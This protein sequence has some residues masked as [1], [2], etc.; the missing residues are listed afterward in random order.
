MGHPHPPPWR[1]K[2]SVGP[3]CRS[4]LGC[5]RGGG[6]RLRRQPPAPAPSLLVGRTGPAPPESPCPSWVPAA[7]HPWVLLVG[8]QWAGSDPRVLSLCV[9]RRP[10]SRSPRW[11]RYGWLLVGWVGRLW[12]GLQQKKKKEEE[13]KLSSCSSSFSVN[14]Q[15]FWGKRGAA[16]AW[17][18][19]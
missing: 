18:R 12:K 13:N 5:C 3:P 1:T 6:G 11:E 8:G 4:T 10:A 19:Y 9:L 15:A 14:F 16:W 17:R 7:E 2:G